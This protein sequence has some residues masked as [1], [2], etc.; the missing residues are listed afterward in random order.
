MSV[1]WADAIFL[2]SSFGQATSCPPVLS[3]RAE[4]VVTLPP[5]VEVSHSRGERTFFRAI[6]A[7]SCCYF[8]FCAPASLGVQLMAPATRALLSFP[9]SPFF[10]LNSASAPSTREANRLHPLCSAFGHSA[11]VCCK[12]HR[13]HRSSASCEETPFH[14]NFRRF[15]FRNRPVKKSSL[16]NSHDT[17]ISTKSRPHRRTICREIQRRLPY[18]AQLREESRR[19]FQHRHKCNECSSLCRFSKEVALCLNRED[20]PYHSAV[21]IS[22]F[23]CGRGIVKSRSRKE[24]T[25]VAR[26]GACL[27][28]R[29]SLHGLAS[30]AGN[31]SSCSAKGNEGCVPS[32]VFLSRN[33]QHPV[34]LLESQRGS[35]TGESSPYTCEFPAP[36]CLGGFEWCRRVGQQ[37]VGGSAVP[38]VKQVDLPCIVQ[39]SLHKVRG[40]SKKRPP[41]FVQE[42]QTP[43]GFPRFT[44]K[45]NSLSSREDI[46]CFAIADADPG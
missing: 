3:V 31:L 41:K 43:G 45:G 22:C 15:G 27:Q 39:R 32:R 11:D 38:D 18:V 16:L 14:R 24:V 10:H 42:Q 6:Q 33:C 29:H 5:C 7:A 21:A 17:N 13:L 9:L 46:R 28:R 35:P 19:Y 23:Y 1:V 20:D 37:V 4:V 8:V 44:R 2:C 40:H 26:T 34:S 30:L 36:A 12:L 25:C